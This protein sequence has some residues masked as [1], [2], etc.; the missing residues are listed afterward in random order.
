MAIPSAQL[1]TWSHQGSVAQSSDTYQAIKRTLEDSSVPYAGK[2]Y[3]VFL[4]G[5]YG[6][7]TNIYKESDV[8]IVIQ[9]NSGFFHDTSDLN[10]SQKHSFE[11]LFPDGTYKYSTFKSEVIKVLKDKYGADAEAGAK[12]IAIAASG[13]RRK[14]DVIAAFQFRRYFSFVSFENQLYQDGICFFAKDG[15]RI[16]NYPKLH[17]ANLTK[18]HQE[19]SNRFKP[20]A[21]ILKNMRTRLV[22]SGVLEPGDAPSYYIE[23]LLYNVPSD[24][25]V[26]SQEM[27]FLD[28]LIYLTDADMKEL[29]CANEMYHLLREDSPVT[30][31]T[32]KCTKFLSSLVDMWTQW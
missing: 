3:S 4:Q 7:D 10:E 27:T 31:R 5:S 6:N 23:G 8:D 15:T 17:S 14:A 32:E 24:K 2:D 16:V 22:D 13:S 18:K 19:T 1:E 30:W 29:V 28:S 11:T 9:C 25:F 26:S 21:R 12:A 20:M